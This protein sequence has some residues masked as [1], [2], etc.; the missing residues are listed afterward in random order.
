MA[1]DHLR[2]DLHELEA[3]RR[4]NL[5]ERREFLVWYAEWLRARGIVRHDPVEDQ[6]PSKRGRKLAGR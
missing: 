5:E 3:D 4:K 2:I 6:G 1:I